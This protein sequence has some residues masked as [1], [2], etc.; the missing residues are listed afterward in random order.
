MLSRV[1]GFPCHP[2]M[3]DDIY[4]QFS[5]IIF[6][7]LN[8]TLTWFEKIFDKRQVFEVYLWILCKL[9]FQHNTSKAS[10]KEDGSQINF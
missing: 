8:W 10:A 2:T 6:E 4:D 1:K 9:L 5:H 3:V 7:K